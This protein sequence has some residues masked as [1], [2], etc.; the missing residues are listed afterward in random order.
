MKN[1]D[2]INIDFGKGDIEGDN[3]V[4]DNRV[5]DFDNNFNESDEDSNIELEGESGGESDWF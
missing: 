3:R 1:Q 5:G 4:G 2:I